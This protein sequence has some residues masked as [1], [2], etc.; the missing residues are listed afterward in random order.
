MT[1]M[2]SAVENVAKQEGVD[3]SSLR[4]AHA[5]AENRINEFKDALQQ[6]LPTAEYPAID[7]VLFGSFGRRELTEDSDCDYLIILD[8]TVDHLSF[9]RFHAEVQLYMKENGFKDPGQQGTFG[10]FAA[11]TDLLM[12]I[13]LDPDSNNTTTR[14]LLFLMESVSVY[15]ENIRRE[16]FRK[17]LERYCDDYHPI[18]HP[19]DDLLK[20]PRFLC[21]DVVRYWRTIAVD[22]AAKRWHSH[23][24]DWYLRHAKLLISRKVLFAGSLM[25]LFLVNH[26]LPRGGSNHEQYDWLLNYLEQEFNRPPLARLLAC[27]DVVQPGSKVALGK[28]L[29]A[30]NQFIRIL[31]QTHKRKLFMIPLDGNN[32]DRENLDQEVQEISASIQSGLQTVFFRDEHIQP[33]TEEYGLF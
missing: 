30:Y 27:Y 13:G 21:N 11:G 28:V 19:S 9:S 25:P 8:K 15:Q 24:P 32:A 4:D 2:D 7:V 6:S 3:I 5:F 22:F 20:V 16:L 10:T 29:N 26:Y 1:E 18:N 17:I 23:V 31:Q 12:T 33:L 14:R